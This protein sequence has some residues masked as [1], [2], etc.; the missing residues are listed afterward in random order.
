MKFPN[1]RFSTQRCDRGDLIRRR[2]EGEMR[3]LSY[4]LEAQDIFE[5][6]ENGL[7]ASGFVLES[8]RKYR[9]VLDGRLEEAA[10]DIGGD[11]L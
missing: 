11:E 2:G 1:L 6:G 8:R 5:P 9:S 3:I 10:D 7:I 4:S